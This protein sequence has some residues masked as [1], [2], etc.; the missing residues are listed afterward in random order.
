MNNWCICWFFTHILTK[1][2]VQEAK[3]PV[4]NL[5]RQRCTKG[6]KGLMD[7]WMRMEHWRAKSDIPGKKPRPQ[8][9]FVQHNFYAQAWYRSRDAAVRDEGSHVSRSIHLFQLFSSLLHYGRVTRYLI[10]FTH[11]NFVSWRPTALFKTN[12]QSIGRTTGKA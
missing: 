10:W 11:E 3:S 12:V 5:V 1:C 2:M 4:K 7:E 8:C 6:L 9:H